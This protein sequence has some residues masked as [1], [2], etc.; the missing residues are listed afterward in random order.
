MFFKHPLNRLDSI[1]EFFRSAKCPIKNELALTIKYLKNDTDTDVINQF[2]ELEKTETNTNEN[3]SANFDADE[4]EDETEDDE[5]DENKLKT[6]LNKTTQLKIVNFESEELD[7][8]QC[9]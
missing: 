1:L 8:D 7:S 4:D 2:S 3:T 5:V 6:N 9:Y